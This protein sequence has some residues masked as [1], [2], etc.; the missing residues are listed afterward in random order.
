MKMPLTNS[1]DILYYT[2]RFYPAIS[3]AEFYIMNLALQMQQN[4]KHAQIICST[5]VD[6]KGLRS[7]NGSHVDISHPNYTTYK[8]LSVRRISPEFNYKEPEFLQLIN[9]IDIPICSSVFQMLK[10][11]PNHTRFFTY[12]IQEFSRNPHVK[13]KLIHSTYLPY[14]TILFALIFSQKLQIPSVCTPFYHIYNPRYQD[15]SFISLLGFYDRILACTETEKQWL[16]KEGI[17]SD[18]ILT[19]PMGV[20]PKLYESFPKTRSGKKKSFKQAFNI[21]KP[22]VLFCG[23]KNYEKGAISVL[24]AAASRSDKLKEL[25][26]VFIGPS[27]AAFDSELKKT[28][29]Y[30]INIV[31]IT[32]DNLMGFYDWR[33]I[34]AFQEC[35]LYIMPSRSD[36]YGISY[37]EAW[38]SKKPVIGADTP[39]MREVIRHKKDGLL[40]EFDNVVQISN[41][42]EFLLHNPQISS[43]MGILGHNKI[44]KHNLWEHVYEKTMHAYNQLI[45]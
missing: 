18:K 39:V 35:S 20:N 5:S 15:N 33:K 36:A 6:F 11:G 38:A 23:N 26:F 2:P 40:V 34:S 3:G 12:L 13:P 19:I 10:N 37:L 43:E 42:I 32:P 29:K 22:F 24:K 28:R 8:N 30:G 21:T 4:L 17:S 7:P 1:F 9:G 27:S 44:Q 14:A 45:Q 41:A 16:V 31:N 25:S